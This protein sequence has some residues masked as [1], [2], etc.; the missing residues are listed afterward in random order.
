MQ[1]SIPFQCRMFNEGYIK[2][3]R[4]TVC[5]V[6]INTNFKNGYKTRTD[7]STSMMLIRFLMLSFLVWYKMVE[8]K[9]F[10]QVSMMLQN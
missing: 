3:E 10:W 9:I 4:E 8:R 1:K 7:A 2:A 5:C 6:D